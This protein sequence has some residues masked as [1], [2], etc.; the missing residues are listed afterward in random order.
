MVPRVWPGLKTGLAAEL[1]SLDD[2]FARR[3]AFDLGQ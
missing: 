3:D 2:L 1:D